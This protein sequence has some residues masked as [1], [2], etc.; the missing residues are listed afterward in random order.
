[1]MCHLRRVLERKNDNCGGGAFQQKVWRTFA[2][3][4]EATI[5]DISMGNATGISMSFQTDF[6]Y[7]NNFIMLLYNKYH[8]SPTRPLPDTKVF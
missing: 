3:S 8:M 4:K 7:T 2:N 1:M 6:I 5:I